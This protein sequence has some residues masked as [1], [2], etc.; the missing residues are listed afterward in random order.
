MGKGGELFVVYLLAELDRPQGAPGNPLPRL[1]LT[2]L[3][4]A[5]APPHV[6]LLDLRTRS[7]T[8]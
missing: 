7:V 8:H 1:Y 4:P 6:V 5:W 2:T 3:D